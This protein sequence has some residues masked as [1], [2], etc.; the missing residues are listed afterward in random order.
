MK[1]SKLSELYLSLDENERIKFSD[2]V[3]SPYFNKSGMLTK[4]NKFLSS[5]SDKFFEDE[6]SAEKIWGKVAGKK[7]FTDSS[8]RLMVSQYTSLLEKFLVV[9]RVLSLEGYKNKFLLEELFNRSLKSLFDKK[10]QD[11]KKVLYE[12]PITDTD[13]QYLKYD[14]ELKT[15]HMQILKDE[16]NH[17]LNIERVSEELD[18]FYYNVK[19]N[20]KHIIEHLEKDVQLTYKFQIENID[21][22]I[23]KIE[24]EIS[25]N[26][27]SDVGLYIRYLILKTISNPEEEEHYFNLKK[28]IV[29]N[30]SKLHPEFLDYIYGAMKNYCQTKV[31]IG[32]EKFKEERYDIY[33]HI[34]DSKYFRKSSLSTTDFLNSVL[35]FLSVNKSSEASNFI[36]NNERYLLKE[37]KD[38]T[39]NL[40]NAHICFHKKKTN[41][42]IEYL[43]K[44]GYRNAYF[45]LNSRSLL[46]RLYFD[47][48][49]LDSA[50]YVADAAKQYLKRNRDKIPVYEYEMFTNYFKIFAMLLKSGFKRD[51]ILY[52]LK[53]MKSISG[54]KW[55]LEK[56]GK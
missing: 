2:F 15:F 37:I 28:I 31:L 45:Y 7:T 55:L 1:K 21:G 27:I 24:E 25:A 29:E 39:V 20:L 49:K 8:Y 3:S 5:N 9:N 17:E 44:T 46:T 33:K 47:E 26:K 10:C 12:K 16:L 40:A 48:G 23:N 52:E 43:N 22:I 4:F 18:K 53:K 35:V 6:F 38:D 36:I 41:L 14:L 13:E 30:E 34:E 19:L 32:E 11:T 42:A 51:E 56:L 54:R 50:E